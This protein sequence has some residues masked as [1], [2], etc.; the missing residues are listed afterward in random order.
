MHINNIMFIYIILYLYLLYIIY[1][2]T[3]FNIILCFKY[4]YFISF[5]LIIK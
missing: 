1:Y 4:D 5:A 2:Y 3:I